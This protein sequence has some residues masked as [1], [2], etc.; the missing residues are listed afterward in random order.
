ML[1]GGVEDGRH[2]VVV[3]RRVGTDRAFQ[4][5]VRRGQQRVDRGLDMLGTN[6]VE[7]G[8]GVGA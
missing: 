4:G 5:G 8:Q 1:G 6:L 7:G 2:R 3:C